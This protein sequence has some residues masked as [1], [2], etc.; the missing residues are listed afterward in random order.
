MNKKQVEIDEGHADI[1]PKP[2]KITFPAWVDE[3]KTILAKRV[4]RGK[5]K[6]RTEREYT[7]TLARAVDAIGHVE[8]RNLGKRDLERFADSYG[9]RRLRRNSREGDARAR[10]LPHRSR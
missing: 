4:Q 7:A 5:L 9:E 1:E 6:A 8:L 10:R 3:Y 2:E